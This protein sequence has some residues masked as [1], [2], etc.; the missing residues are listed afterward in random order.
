MKVL[1][2]T[3][4]LVYAHDSASPYQKR[5]ASLIKRALSGRIEAVIS[6][7]NIAELFSV[8]TS[9]RKMGNPLT[10]SEA[11]KICKLYLETPE[12]EKLVPNEAAL[13]RGMELAVKVNYRAGDFF[14]CLIAATMESCGVKR[15]YTENLADFKPFEFID[16][17]FP[18][19]RGQKR[20]AKAHQKS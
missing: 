1:I 8:L 4:L 13:L 11:F 15:I 2:D 17:V 9:E 6:T 14:D 12:L 3:N 20:R 19:P 5:V 18:F 10:P 7:Q 16:A